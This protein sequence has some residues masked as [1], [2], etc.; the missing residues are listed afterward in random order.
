LPE[1][2]ATT[3]EHIIFGPDWPGAAAWKKKWR[4]LTA[5]NL[6]GAFDTLA[7][8]DNIGDKVSAIRVPTQIIRGDADA[9]IPIAKAQAMQASIP[10][11]ELVVV[12][13]GH[14]VNM[15]NPAPVNAAIEAFLAR[16]RLV[17]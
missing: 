8:R 7:R 14:S 5:P 17:P 1:E 10:N 13:G 15:T 16:H 12:E 3:L 6:R 11:A 2:I 4:T 9:A